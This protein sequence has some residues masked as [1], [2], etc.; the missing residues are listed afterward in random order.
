VSSSLRS[1]PPVASRGTSSPSPALAALLFAFAALL[2]TLGCGDEAA[3]AL[4]PSFPEQYAS[5][6]MEVRDCRSSSE[7][8]FMRVRVL[9]DPA[10]LQPYLG[11]D[12]DFPVG[13]VVLKEEYDFADTACA[14]DVIRWT[15][16]TRLAT[17]S[18]PETLD[19]YWQEVDAS[20]RVESENESRCIGC[21]TGCGVPPEGYRGT[22]TV[23]GAGGGASP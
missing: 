21:H 18:S 13:S 5:T 1:F 16:M 20:R 10:A 8:E 6:Y 22:C 15:V 9:A 7:H 14:G 4:A 2:A 19:W 3:S 23:V 12:A 17:G 11:R